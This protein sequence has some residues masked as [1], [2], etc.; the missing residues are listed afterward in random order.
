MLADWYRGATCA[1]CGKDI[2]EIHRVEHKP[3]LLTPHRQTV[4]WDEVSVESLEQVLTTHQR[5]C[6]S[7]H[8]ASS[9]RER[10]P[11]LTMERGTGPTYS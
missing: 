3:A 2:P 8:V 9:L 7:C 6:W 10:F 11:G 5:V 1:L 4:E